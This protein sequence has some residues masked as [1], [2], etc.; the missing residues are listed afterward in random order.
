M[1]KLYTLFVLMLLCSLTAMAANIKTSYVGTLNVSVN[2]S[3]STSEQTVRAKDNGNGTVTIVI[4]N[5]TYGIFSGAATVK[6]D[7]DANGN[8]TNPKV[9]FSIVT[10]SSMSMSD[11]WLTPTSCE[12]H[13]TMGANNDS[14]MVDFSGN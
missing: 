6:A 13:L 14:I 1:K 7:I 4:P 5:F 3:V 12:I 11:S 10:I 9:S 8:L 2:G